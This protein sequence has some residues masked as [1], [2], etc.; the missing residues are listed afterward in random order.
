LFVGASV[1]PSKGENRI[2]LI[3]RR[4]HPIRILA[5]LLAALGAALTADV[6]SPFATS[7]PSFGRPTTFRTGLAPSAVA[8]GDLNGDGTRDLATANAGGNSVSVLLSRGG[9]SFGARRD[10]PTGPGP[11]S[12]AIGDVSGDHEPDLATANLAEGTVSVLLNGGNGRFGPPLDYAAGGEIGAASSVAVGDLNGDGKPDLVTS[13]DQLNTISVLANKG[14][15]SFNPK[16]DRPTGASPYA[17][18][19]GDLNGDG[20]R[21]LATANFDASTVSVLL[22]SGDGTFPTRRDYRAA[23]SPFSVVIGDLNGD[24][25][26]DLATANTNTH[27]KTVSVLLNTGEGSFGVR[28]DYRAG[29]DP[30]AVAIGD[31]NGDRRPDLATAN[32]DADAETVSVLLNR[33]GGR[34]EAKLDYPAGRDPW[35]VAI[36][37]LTGD[38]RADLAAANAYANTVSVLANTPGLCAV[39]DVRG[40]TVPAAKQTIARANCG[41]GTIRRAYSKT[42]KRGR[43]ISEKPA[44]GTVLRRGGKVNL[45]ISRG[46]SG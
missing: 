30:Y 17:V 40:M 29:N 9:G 35:G 18:A 22:N 19:I 33:G 12:V 20:K 43:V 16:L 14:D 45:V 36:G 10:Y 13:N 46:P 7:A 1:V 39:Q 23:P 2:A 41:V 42:V 24:G 25:K 11:D 27:G 31:L 38:G 5:V 15:G 44:A 26:A 8:I 28:R 21:D 32:S 34:F 6:V 37:D 3:T 4:R